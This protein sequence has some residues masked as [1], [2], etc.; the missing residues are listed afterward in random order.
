[1]SYKDYVSS[2]DILELAGSVDTVGTPTAVILAVDSD[3]NVLLAKGQTLPTDDDNGY[4]VGCLFIDTDAGVGTTLYINEGSAT[5][6]D[7][8]AIETPG[9]AITGVTAG[10]GISGGGTS[11]TVAVAVAAD[12]P[13]NLTISGTSVIIGRAAGTASILS[14]LY[15]NSTVGAAVRFGGTGT[16][17]IAVTPVNLTSL[18]TFATNT[19]CITA[20]T[21]TGAVVDKIAVK[22]GGGAATAYIHLWD[23]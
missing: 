5:D 21:G 22:I 11:G 10:S 8:N 13:H 15:Y 17:A 2:I 23:T 20:S 4:A 3:K 16:A 9:A 14:D 19:G 6:C 12:I 1:M 18:L 7:F